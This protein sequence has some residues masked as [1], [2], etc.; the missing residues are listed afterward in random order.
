[1]AEAND[2]VHLTKLRTRLGMAV[3]VLA[4]QRA[5]KAA[6]RQFHA[7]GLKPQYMP[8]PTDR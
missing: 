3:M 6:K 5:I 8:L 1:M 4:R 2:S 7:Q